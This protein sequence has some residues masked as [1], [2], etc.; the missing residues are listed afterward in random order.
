MIPGCNLLDLPSCTLYVRPYRLSYSDKLCTVSGEGGWPMWPKAKLTRGYPC[1]RP[2]G[3]RQHSATKLCVVTELAER[4]V[5]ACGSRSLFQRIATKYLLPFRRSMLMSFDEEL[6]SMATQ[7]VV[8]T[9][10]RFLAYS[11]T[12]TLRPIYSDGAVSE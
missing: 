1:V 4:T 2:R 5:F 6:A 7:P 9:R 12:G 3:I 8:R 11:S 10:D